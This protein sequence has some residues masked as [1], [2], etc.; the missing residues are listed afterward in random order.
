MSVADMAASEQMS[1][2]WA[3]FML[4]FYSTALVLVEGQ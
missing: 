3:K 4:K 2:R 1:Y